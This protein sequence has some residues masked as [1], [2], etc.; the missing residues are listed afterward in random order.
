MRIGFIGLGN[1]GSKL[2][3]NLLKNNFD[4]MVFDKNSSILNRFENIGS[5]VAV[6]IED[7]VGNNEI[8]ITCLPSPEGM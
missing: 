2:A 1:V 4:L 6:S 3:N 8:L 5:R 7:L